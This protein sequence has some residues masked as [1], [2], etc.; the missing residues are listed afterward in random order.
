[1]VTLLPW[2]G[3]VEGLGDAACMPAWSSTLGRATTEAIAAAGLSRP[4]LVVRD[5]TLLGPDVLAAALAEGEKRGHDCAFCI[6]GRLGELIGE[7]SLGRDPTALWFIQGEPTPE[8][9]EAATAVIL[10]PNER[11]LDVPLGDGQLPLSDR[12][13]LRVDHHVQL[14]WGNLL[15]LGSSLWRG[16]LH[17][18]PVLASLRMMWGGVLGG[19][20]SGP[21]VARGLSRG[22]GVHGKATVEACLLAEGVVVEPGAVVRGC[23]L[24]PGVRVEANAVLEGAVLGP[25]A[26][27]QRQAMLR[28]GVLGPDVM[29]GG[30]A[31]LAVLGRG[32]SIKL[33]SYLMDQGFDQ[34]I[35]VPVG[36]GFVRAP[37]GLA[38]VC[39]GEGSRIG[40]GV[41]VAPGRVI[42]PKGVVVADAVMRSF[43]RPAPYRTWSEE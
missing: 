6:G 22:P 14:L 25:R 38:G 28:F 15:G 23:V 4:G 26:V 20:F 13:V 29:F 39:M 42:P 11:L 21:R 5:G 35:R 32:A 12:L 24:G 33:G 41:W 18:N 17:R 2:D 3:R 27:V 8:R 10:D 9:L 1:M 34:D 30:T 40:S 31:Q 7:A 43:D 16:L 19:G 36:D 37:L